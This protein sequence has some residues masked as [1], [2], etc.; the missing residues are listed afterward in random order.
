MALFL[1]PWVVAQETAASEYPE[2][3]EGERLIRA[4]DW[5]AAEKWFYSFTRAHSQHAESKRKL[6]YVELHR[7]GGDVV[8]TV[9]YLEAAQRIE[10]AHPVG[11]LLL[12]RA[13]QVSGKLDLARG[14]YDELIALAETDRGRMLDH[15]AHLA[16]FNRALIALHDD[17]FELAVSSFEAVLKREPL[18]A[19][20]VF[21][22]AKIAL[23]AGDDERAVE[24]LQKADRSL[25]MW[26]PLEVWS[27]PQGR[28][29][30][31]MDNV[32]FE[33]G[34]A[35]LALGRPEEARPWLEPLVELTWSRSESSHTVPR[36]AER[37]PLE[38]P[39]DVSFVNAPYFYAETLA[40]AGEDR[41][42]AKIFKEFS[43]M[44]IGDEQLKAA[45]K[46]RARELR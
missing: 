14:I 9:Q 1:T 24:L 3:H 16:R 32:C 21:E 25:R 35:L 44:K 39:V 45:A 37:S 40:A 7:P 22:L 5:K 18:H 6:A 8:R 31:A 13:Y 42:A 17:D 20:A 23:R 36:S 4:R 28:Y 46:N 34:K 30:Y 27:Y 10:P 15:A 11:L 19:F 26:A 38:G 33:L 43:R 29:S 12:G 41:A 2:L